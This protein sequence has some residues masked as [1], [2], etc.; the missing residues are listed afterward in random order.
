[1]MAGNALVVGD[2]FDVEQQAMRRVVLIHVDVAWPAAVGGAGR[3]V[4]GRSGGRAERLHRDDLELRLG[5]MAEEL[6]QLGFHLLRV[7]LV[8]VENLLARFAVQVS[9]RGGCDR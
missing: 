2:G 3:V 4:G 8:E 5:K 1:M 9:D 7:V 6:R